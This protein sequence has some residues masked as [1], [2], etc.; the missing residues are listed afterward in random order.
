[1]EVI[2]CGGG[3]H[4]GRMEDVLVVIAR[5]ADGVWIP[6]RVDEAVAVIE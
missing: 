1:M 6:G 2:T 4:G 5:D 3:V